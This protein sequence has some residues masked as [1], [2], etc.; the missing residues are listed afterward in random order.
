MSPCILHRRESMRRRGM[1]MRMVRTL[2]HILTISDSYGEIVGLWSE[3]KVVV[4]YFC[5]VCEV[6]RSW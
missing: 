6:F 1:I 3:R 4:G 2:S 5:G